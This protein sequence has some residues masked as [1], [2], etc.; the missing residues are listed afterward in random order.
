MPEEPKKQN[1]DNQTKVMYRDMIKAL[2][3]IFTTNMRSSQDISNYLK[4]F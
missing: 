4:E 1:T 2:F 3:D